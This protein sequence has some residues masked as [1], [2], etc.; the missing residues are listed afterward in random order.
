MQ[1]VLKKS[2]IILASKSP[3]RQ[4]LLRKLGLEF[5]IMTKE[6]EETY[7]GN[8]RKEK[9]ALYLCELKANAFKDE[10][11][12]NTI[13]IA[14]DTIV[15]LDGQVMDKPGNYN[16][17]VR[18]LELLSGRMHEVITGVCFK[19]NRETRS[20]YS[21]TKVFF[22]PLTR[23]SIKQYVEKYKPYDKAGAYGIQECM[24][25]NGKGIGT[26]GIERIE[27][28]YYNVM[29]LPIEELQDELKGFVKLS[30]LQKVKF[31]QRSSFIYKGIN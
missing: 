25:Q 28:S 11:D 3:R 23:E 17:A 1:D 19:T 10:I 26:I 30:L 9:I 2:R 13:V 20:F 24:T 5:E 22:K 29:G 16:E 6:V 8:L 12:D 21:V 31:H 15:W 4:H 7:H 18:I 14:A 27:G